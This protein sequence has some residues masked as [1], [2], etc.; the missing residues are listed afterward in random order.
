MDVLLPELHRL[1]FLLL[2][3]VVGYAVGQ[4]GARRT[5]R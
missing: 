5:R 4:R 2:G 1:G 3:V